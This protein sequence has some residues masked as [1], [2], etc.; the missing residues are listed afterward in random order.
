[1]S[2]NKEFVPSLTLEP[3][4]EEAPQLAVVEET[5]VQEQKINEPVLTAEEQQIVDT[6]AQK[7]DVENTAQ[8]LQYVPAPRRKW[9]ISPM[10]PLPMYAPRTWARW[11]I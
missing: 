5:A 2:E 3:D 8:I 7:I 9:R 11:A 10:Q 4:L 1:M 6:F